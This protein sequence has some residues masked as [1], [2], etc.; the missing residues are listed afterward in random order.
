MQSFAWNDSFVT[1]FATVDVQHRNLFDL[2]NRF[3]ALLAQG[4]SAGGAALEAIFKELATY[5]V[6]H[7]KEEERL[8]REAGVP[9]EYFVHH[10]E[11]H[12]DFIAQVKVLW[13]Q[14]NNMS[15]PAETIHGFLAAWLSAHILGEDQEMARQIHR[16]KGE[17]ASS[18]ADG[19]AAATVLQ[20]AMRLLYKELARLNKDLAETNRGLEEK[21]ESR[22]RALVDTNRQLQE[23]QAELTR[24]LQKVQDTQ[25]Q[26][27]QSEKMASIG[28][29]AAG[30]AHEIN[31]P[32][33]FVTSNLGTLGRY[34]DQLLQLAELGA[35]TP[36]GQALKQ[37]IDL[38][39]LKT[40]LDDLLRETHD[41][42][43]RV[44]TIV[45][46]LKDFSRV[47]QAAWQEADLLAGLESTLN[48]TA[49]ELKYKAEIVREL[50]PLPP[51]RCV[52]AQINQV[53]LNLLMNAAQAIPERG[54]ITLRSR[55]D[56]QSVWIEI[57]DS[58]CGMDATTQRRMFE[59]FFTTK[60]VGAG[61]GLGMSLTYD[62]VKKHG[63]RIDVGS[64]L[65]QGTT[66]RVSLPIA[67]P[68]NGNA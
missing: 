40:D 30:V 29:L 34:G 8:M 38:D 66:I 10:A 56:A 3:G 14:R 16:A 17:P 43:E 26:L 5:A 52:P 47:D 36:A 2:I 7:F 9:E 57:A 50:Q 39:Y 37:E 25:S 4:P 21:V 45:A 53:F 46:N 65:G 13:S 54:T 20:Q 23:E 1:G 12:R 61:T 48:V 32:I 6:T 49:H 15:A 35:A 51:V 31:N 63:G 24:L 18:G 33:G 22:T 41:G 28:Q 64:T 11:I 58:G 67:G 59:P 60:P 19:T 44:R 55:A 68:A 42:L 62:I 27:L